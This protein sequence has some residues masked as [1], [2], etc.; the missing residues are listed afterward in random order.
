MRV[1]R[2]AGLVPAAIEEPAGINPAAQLECLH[3]FRASDGYTFYYRH[4]AAGGTALARLVLV[5]GI[6]SHGGWYEHSCQKFAGAGFDVYFLDRRGAGLNTAHRGDGPNF[7]RL[8]DDVVE[9][10]QNLRRE[11]G[12]LPIVLGGISWGGKLAAGLPYR[13]PGLIDGLILLCPGLAPIVA[14]PF[15][16]R[17]RIAMARVVRP[18]KFF[19]IPLNEPH[20]FTASREWQVFI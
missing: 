8:L 2:A 1:E 3:T 14:P 4:Y 19:P 7:R 11:R 20:L 15:V 10:A 5:H 17:L 16:R 12:S 9:F 13:K 18:W 6:R